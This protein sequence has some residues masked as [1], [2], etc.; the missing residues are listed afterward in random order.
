MVKYK[1]IGLLLYLT[2]TN[3]NAWAQIPPPLISV[4]KDSLKTSKDSVP[5]LPYS[6][7]HT[8][9]GKLFLAL[10]S[11]K[12]IIYDAELKQYMIIE[13][14]GNYEIKYPVYMSSETYNEYVQKKEMLS[15]FKDKVSAVDG[16]KKN[17]EAQQKD[18]LPSYYVNSS[19]FESIFGG[20]V[21]EVKPQG[22]ISVKMGMLYQKVENPQVSERN[23]S[24]VTFD[25]DQQI[26]AS[27]AA[28]VGNRLKVSADYDTQS[29]FDFQN[30]V[31]LEYT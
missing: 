30:L 6:F 27:I 3:I 17:I 29:T 5:T 10:P 13:K 1:W 31:K 21:I 24:S 12:E 26:S 25:F 2:I 4:S 22:S 7:N 11:T 8:K 14:I 15:Y 16:K 19:F 9:D 18:L 23:R 28:K 20:N